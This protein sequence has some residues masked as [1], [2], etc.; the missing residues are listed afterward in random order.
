MY[1]NLIC[2]GFFKGMDP[3][4]KDNFIFKNLF[5]LYNMYI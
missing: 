4:M 2:P 5:I 3:L 1:L